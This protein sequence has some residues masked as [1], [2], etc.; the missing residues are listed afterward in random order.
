MKIRTRVPAV[1]LLAACFVAFAFPPS[2]LAQAGT[3]AV[4]GIV[5][6]ADGVPI[7]GA[8]VTLSG[9]GTQHTVTADKKGLFGISGL[10]GGTYNVRVDAKGYD[11]VSGRTVDV[12]PGG[13][14]QLTLSMA[15]STTSLTVIGQ[16]RANGQ[17]T[18]S[19]SS[20]PTVDVNTQAYADVGYTRVS[21]VLDNEISTTLIH[22]LGG[23]PLL[24]TSVALRGPDP[25]ETLVDVDGHAV[26]NG[27]TGDFDLS[28]LDPADFSAVQLIYGISPSSLVGPNTIDGAI[29]IRT[30]EPTTDPHGVLR[31]SAGS[32][33][34]FA[35]TLD[36]TGTADR[37][38]YA[39]SLHRTTTGGEVNEN[40]ID[41]D[42]GQQQF[43]GSA[44]QGSTALGKLRYAFGSG[45]GYIGLTFH[46]QSYYK[47]YSAALTS[48]P[49]PGGSSSSSDDG[50][51]RTRDESD[52]GD[53]TS[54]LPV[55]D[56][57][58]G[59][60][61]LGH[62]AAYGLD[63]QV[64]LGRTDA[65]GIAKT[66]ALL[67]WMTSDASQ[68]VF[69]AGAD[70]DPYLYNNKDLVGDGILEIDQRLRN[71]SLTLQLNLHNENLDTDFV[72]GVV[73]DESVARRPLDDSSEPTPAPAAT[74]AAL[75]LGQTERSA[76]LRWTDDP[77]STLHFTL[78]AYYSDFS[79]FGTSLDPR[80]GF[81]WTP[82][83]STA[84]RVSVGTTFQI[85]QLPELFVPPVLPPP[86]GGYINIGN[87]ALQP[88]RATDYGLGFE[89]FFGAGDSRTHVSL[90]L[91]RTNLRNPATTL[92]PP[93]SNNPDCGNSSADALL[94]TKAAATP[95]CPL[96]YPVNAGNAVYQGFELRA[97]RQVAAYTTVRAGYS[98]NSAYLTAV[99]PNVQDGTLVIGEQALGLPLQKGTLSIDR[100]P[101]LGLEYGAALIY[102]GF[103]N[104][105]DQPKFATL[106]AMLGYRYQ[107]YEVNLA[108]TNLTNVYA[109]KFTMENAGIPYGGCC[110][111]GPIPTDAYAMQG[112][113]FTL[114][115]ARRY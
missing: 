96:S 41:A 65:A 26:N 56:S 23:S 79:T 107:K 111:T 80:A 73:N 98:V 8:V 50:L 78:A 54:G 58:A 86:V 69:G 104:G 72:P 53:D 93:L 44:V 15:R 18:V 11:P 106:S 109:Y 29:N 10:S 64:P 48:I 39:L 30:L 33:N 90:D 27:N 100:R 57:F 99:P 115:V 43:V 13:G 35:A 82:N 70:T 19:T 101:P 105:Y 89:H 17:Q 94:R 40:V 46:D 28:L 110:G 75:D 108:A 63:L 5:T 49:P 77:T 47:D 22:P 36:A 34:A 97:D 51:L 45:S 62:N 112:T 76:V 71:G 14:A 20:A 66:T 83:A 21:D 24:P 74:P 38:G 42:S 9:Y 85:P 88:D 102:Q 4:V 59:T 68:S 67:R 32:W 60:Y 95:S 87:P 52:N 31:L 6:S 7:P 103:Y 16:V 61:T 3:G 1:A 2:A 81:V 91:Y 113:Q 114:T 55:V 84:V 25:T 92:V 12:P 37:L